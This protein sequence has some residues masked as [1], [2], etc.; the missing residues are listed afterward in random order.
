MKVQN[1]HGIQ[2]VKQTIPDFSVKARRTQ[3][4]D[5]NN[6]QWVRLQGFP[7]HNISSV[8]FI[9]SCFV[10]LF[11]S[12]A[13]LKAQE[14]KPVFKLTKHSAPVNAVSWSPD[15]KIL[16]T[17]SDDNSVIL[18]DAATGKEIITLNGH[19]RAVNAM[20][21]TSD[22]KTLLTAG[23]RNILVWTSEGAR[24]RTISGATTDFHSLAISPDD[25]IV[26]GGTYDKRIPVWD[27]QTGKLI[28]VLEGHE[29][30]VLA[31][32]ISPDGKYLASGS[33][34]G[35]VRLWDLDTYKC[36]H[37]WHGHGGNIYTVCF[38]P[39]SKYVLSGSKD[40]S[41]R[42]WDISKD[43]SVHTYLGHTMA[44][45]CARFSPNGKW[46][47]S[48]GYDRQVILWEVASGNRIFQYIGFD[49]P[50]NGVAFNPAGDKFATAS[51]DRK[52]MI[53]DFNTDLFVDYY[54]A[55]EVKQAM[56]TMAIFKPRDKGESR[57]VYEQRTEKAAREKKDLYAKYYRQYLDKLGITK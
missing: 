48:A 4:Q 14:E 40:N 23:D 45:M 10:L 3:V 7:A 41:L 12:N 31:V 36:L 15:G 47:L 25:R 30:S 44:V 42:L 43:Q 29:K 13:P 24:I 39:D 33:L 9:V 32:C 35:T 54:Y 5:F 19:I 53:W 20:V 8:L 27:F 34:D 57:E 28:K 55:N 21:W 50:V 37:I 51:S 17:G 52:A 1:I 56:D 38:S 6:R 46:I 2:A 22:G 18:W 16:V 26:S 11:L 49:G